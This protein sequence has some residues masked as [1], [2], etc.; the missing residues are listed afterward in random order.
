MIEPTPLIAITVFTIICIAVGYYYRHKKT[1]EDFFM[2]G[3]KVGSIR[4]IAS[5]FTLFGAGEI[6]TLTAFAYLYGIRGLSLFLGVVFGFLGLAFLSH[7]IRKNSQEYK[8]YSLT[9]YVGNFLGKKS[10]KLSIII[11]L[12]AV[13]S[14]LII[15][16]VV[17]GLLISTL[18]GLSYPISVI[19]IGVV[20]A[21]YLSM[22]GFNSSLTTDVI[23]AVSMIILLVVLL[24]LY[25]PSG[26]SLSSIISH[27]QDIVPPVDFV[28]L[29]ILG[30]F[31]VLGSTDVYQSIFASSSDKSVKKSLVYTGILWIVFSS[32]ML[33][34][35]LKIFYQLPLVDPNNAFFDFLSSGLSSSLLAILSIFIVASLFSTADT[36]LFLASILIGRL[37]VKKEKLSSTF[38][39]ITMWLIIIAS[40]GL[41]I[42]F[43]AL[44]EIYFFLLYMF[45]ILGVVML[46]N[47]F[48]RGNDLF[49]F[50]GMLL[51]LVTVLLLGV[52]NLLAGWYLLLILVAP[53][54]TF[55]V[56]SN[57]K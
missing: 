36:E 30:F 52:F 12:I 5:I 46:A 54:I 32:L 23:Q 6:V 15:Q 34:L 39:Q 1:P 7:R 14:L 28:V 25:N 40:I 26:V 11:S 13:L 9:D 42:Y 31:V 33:L 49:A 57:K 45:S 47:L 29:F 37:F 22:G 21:I 3:R 24:I 4:I 8:P 20:I 55:L 18:T 19:I 51:S 35:G 53:L 10:E 41:A 17:G 27:A 38:S 50:L 16:L 44:V 2:A 43:T 56:P 48:G